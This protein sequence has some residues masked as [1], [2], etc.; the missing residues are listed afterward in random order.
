MYYTYSSVEK[1]ETVCLLFYANMEFRLQDKTILQT[2][3][4]KY[5][6]DAILDYKRLGEDIRL[7]QSIHL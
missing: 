3:F 4:L 2:G 7:F 6:K 1:F 5:S